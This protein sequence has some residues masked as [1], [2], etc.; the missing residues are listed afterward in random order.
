MLLHKKRIFISYSSV[1]RTVAI[2]ASKLFENLGYSVWIDY[3]N[4]DLRF[5][6]ELQIYHALQACEY[7]AVIV[8]SSSKMSDWVQLEWSKAREMHKS[9]FV[10]YADAFVGL[11]TNSKNA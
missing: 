3:Q 11:E 7:F 10:L 2:K 5:C 9:I 8:S 4:L 6:V 1:D